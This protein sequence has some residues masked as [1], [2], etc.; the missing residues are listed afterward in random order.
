MS[1]QVLYDAFVSLNGV[2][3]SAQAKSISIPMAIAVLDVAAMG[4]DTVV[5]EPGLKSFS[6]EVEFNSDFTD[7]ELD[8]DLFTL[9]DA[10]TKFAIKIRHNKTSAISATNPEYQF[11][12]FISGWNPIQG[13]KGTI[14]GGTI[15][16]SNSSV[17]TRDVTP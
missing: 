13:A 1:A 8:E 4:T 10:R 11:D 3:V 7:N 14:A 2:D 5:N 15:S 6:A 16:L 12:G 17:M 9:W